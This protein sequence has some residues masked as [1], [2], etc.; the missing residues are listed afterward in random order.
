MTETTAL[1]L[2][3]GTLVGLDL[4]S[5]PQLMVTRPL[6]AGTVA[7][8]I[9]GDLTAGVTVGVVLELFA[10]DLLPVGA[11]RYPDYG[12][13]AV[14]A[15]ATAAGAPGVLGIGVA[16]GVGLLVA[17]LGEIAIYFVRRKN[18][19]DV[20]GNRDRLDLGEIP[21]I[22]ALHFRGIARDAARALILTGVGLL[23]ATAVRMWP[24]V[25]VR[26]AVLVSLALVGAALSAAVL[27]AMRI[28]GVGASLRWFAVGVT[29]GVAFVVLV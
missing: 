4:V 14:A 21:V 29:A 27:G 25:T 12:L 19:E 1:L 28:G 20:R 23:L 18:T 26:G 3:W 9:T 5:V 22:R 8:V 17:Y 13:G 2:L 24:P 6:V 10:L 11:A 15:T 7:G 16:V